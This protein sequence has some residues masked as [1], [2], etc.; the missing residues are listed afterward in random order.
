MPQSAYFEDGGLLGPSGQFDFDGTE[1]G[2]V[3]GIVSKREGEMVLKVT[4]SS[5]SQTFDSQGSCTLLNIDD[6]KDL[7]FTW[8]ISI[9]K[10]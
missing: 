1:F 10:L 6:H 5:S 7:L 9:K 4:A 2:A 8:S 3:N